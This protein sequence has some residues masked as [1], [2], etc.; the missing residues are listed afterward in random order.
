MK[1]YETLE[2]NE[3]EI[4]RRIENKH[5]SVKPEL[6]KVHSFEMTIQEDITPRA[7]SQTVDNINE[8]EIPIKSEPNSPA[9]PE[10]FSFFSPS[11]IL[12]PKCLV[13]ISRV[14]FFDIFKRI[15][16][17][18]YKL[19]TKSLDIPVE[20]YIAHL[21]LQVPL[22]P[23]GQLEVLYHLDT[24][25]FRFSLP[26]VNSLP[27]LDI[28]LGTL[29]SCLDLDNIIRIFKYVCLEHSIVFISANE[30]RLLTCSYGI[31]SLIF[32]FH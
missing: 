32:P 25:I 13:L 20:C 16:S 24:N 14:P 23:K 6:I 18:L 28:N 1:I 31:L 2:N 3:Q 8:M 17:E 27:L 15:L 10:S 5:L 26:A 21:I 12:V 19:S 4:F 9:K 22:P 11:G 29:F 30:D 7:R